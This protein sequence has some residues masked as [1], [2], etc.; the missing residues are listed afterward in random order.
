MV[1]MIQPLPQCHLWL[2][3]KEDDE[4]EILV[5]LDKPTPPVTKPAMGVE[6]VCFCLPLWEQ[7]FF[8]FSIK[9]KILNQ[10][11]FK[12]YLHIFSYATITSYTNQTISLFIKS[13]FEQN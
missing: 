10:L 5:F 8:T 11:D 12:D 6:F 4:I 3:Y 9:A 1:S 13:C 7:I 2:G